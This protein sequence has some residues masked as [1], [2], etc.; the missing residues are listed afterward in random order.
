VF[1]M[2]RK[3]LAVLAVAVFLALTMTSA[4][5]AQTPSAPE[6]PKPGDV[7]SAP[8]GAQAEPMEAQSYSNCPYGRACIF[9]GWHG[10]GN[11]GI[12]DGCNTWIDLQFLSNIASSAKTHGNAMWLW[13]Y[14]GNEYVG[15]IKPWT[16]TN[17]SGWENNRADAAYVVC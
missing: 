3:A 10:T 4:A 14:V 13:D 1:A 6:P 9:D 12:M 11:W 5:M 16:Q 15:Y 7:R 17:L 2:I 8:D